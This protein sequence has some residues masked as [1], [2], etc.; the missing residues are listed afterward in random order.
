MYWIYNEIGKNKNINKIPD[1][2][3][4]NIILIKIIIRMINIISINNLINIFGIE[5]Y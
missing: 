2:Q 3:K 5:N 1:I 4:K